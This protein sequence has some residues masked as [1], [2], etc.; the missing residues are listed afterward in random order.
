MKLTI[1]QTVP[2]HEVKRVDCQVEERKLRVLLDV[3]NNRRYHH[4]LRPDTL[5]VQP[6][7]EEFQPLDHSLAA[8][9]SMRIRLPDNFTH[10]YEGWLQREVFEAQI[11]WDQLVLQKTLT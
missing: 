8:A 3:F 2:E 5:Y 6:G 10:D 7:L 4:I 1:R 11:D 9:L